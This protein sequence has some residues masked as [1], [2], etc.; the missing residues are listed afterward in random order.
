MPP[1]RW[2]DT[3]YV[4]ESKYFIFVPLL[5]DPLRRRNLIATS[6]HFFFRLSQQFTLFSKES[7]KFLC[8]FMGID[9]SLQL[10]SFTNIS[11]LETRKGSHFITKQFVSVI[12]GW[13]SSDWRSWEHFIFSP[14][15]V[16]IVYKWTFL[17]RDHWLSVDVKK[18]NLD[19]PESPC[20]WPSSSTPINLS[21]WIPKY[22]LTLSLWLMG[23]IQ[24]P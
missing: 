16:F 10:N 17:K 13:T 24:A 11:H 15:L 9:E 18:E 19:C 12:Y 5:F 8:K 1:E 2:T 22:L 14:F 21:F 6:K 23:Y 3:R 20:F 7:W 4:F